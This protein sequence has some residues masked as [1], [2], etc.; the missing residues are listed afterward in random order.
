ML[1]SC[2]RNKDSTFNPDNSDTNCVCSPVQLATPSEEPIKKPEDVDKR[3]NAVP[4]PDRDTGQVRVVL[5]AIRVMVLFDTIQMP[6]LSA[7]IG[8]FA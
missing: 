5:A 4:V 3:V 6:W 2:A 7:T 1:P 8:P